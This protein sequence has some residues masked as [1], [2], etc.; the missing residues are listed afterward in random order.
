MKLATTFTKS[1]IQ[2]RL[3]KNPQLKLT[4]SQLNSFRISTPSDLKILF[5]SVLQCLVRSLIPLRLGFP[6]KRP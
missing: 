4:M 2:Y 6:S 5:N 1:K 3:Y